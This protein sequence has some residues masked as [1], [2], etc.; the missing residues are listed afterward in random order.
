MILPTKSDRG[1][2]V[3][4]FLPSL[5][6]N[7]R[8]AVSFIIIAAGMALQL[9]S[10][11]VLPGILLVAAGN[12]L[13]VVKGYDNRVDSGAFDVAAQWERVGIE[14]LQELKALDKKMRRWDRSLLD[15]TNP[16]GAVAFV[17]LFGAIVLVVVAS[18]SADN[19][20]GQY[21]FVL[22]L[23]AVVLLL[24]H[25]VTG[26]RSILRR[27]G[28]LVRIEAIEEVLDRAQRRLKDHEVALL[29]LLSGGEVSI[30][31][32]VKFKVDI[33]GRDPDFLGLYGQ[34]VINEV[35]GTSYPYFYVVLVTRKGYGLRD[36]YH[37]HRPGNKITK[38]F[39]YEGEV[40]VMVLRQHTT[41][42]SGYHTKPAVANAI[43]Y[44]GLDLAERVAVRA[45]V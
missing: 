11:A 4:W 13:L 25:W 44:E 40:E 45:A 43:F 36:A 31:E 9:A 18:F 30:P 20:V 8:L 29:M 41:K 24:P 3:F 42:R 32:D 10:G 38:E 23:N 19:E 7:T 26:I 22:G 33:A 14:K 5:A 21:M 6:Y 12:L 2:V 17:L 1:T 39:K 28:L 27:P 16:F 37:D 35:Q 34:V 15:V